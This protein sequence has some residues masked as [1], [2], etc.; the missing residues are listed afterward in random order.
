MFIKDKICLTHLNK[1]IL[2]FTG[3][4]KLVIN[5]TNGNNYPKNDRL[6]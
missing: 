4:T 5:E 1:A 2:D 6:S 3:L